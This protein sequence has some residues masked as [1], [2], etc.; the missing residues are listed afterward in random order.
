MSQRKT[1]I[2]PA[3]RLTPIKVTV[4]HSR[5]SSRWTAAVLPMTKAAKIYGAAPC[6]SGS[7]EQMTLRIGETTMKM[8]SLRMPAQ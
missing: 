8:K 6:H 3:E 7:K 2:R 1:V 5:P 4:S